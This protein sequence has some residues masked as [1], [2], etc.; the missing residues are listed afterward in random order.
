MSKVNDMR[1][2]QWQLRPVMPVRDTGQERGQ[3][4]TEGGAGSGWRRQ[5]CGPRSEVSGGTDAAV[6]AAVRPCR[7]FGGQRSA[8]FG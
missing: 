7:W 8:G 6:A 1:R 4:W 3:W 2:E 5:S